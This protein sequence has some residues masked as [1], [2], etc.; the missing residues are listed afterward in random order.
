MESEYNLCYCGDRNKVVVGWES[1]K[2]G[3]ETEKLPVLLCHGGTDLLVP[4]KLAR[5]AVDTLNRVGLA[6]ILKTYPVMA[7]SFCSQVLA[8]LLTSWP[9]P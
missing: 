3:S 8:L 1:E 6:A 7:H 2:E 9:T 4:S 5:E